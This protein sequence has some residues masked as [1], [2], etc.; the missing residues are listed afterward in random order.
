MGLW[1]WFRPP[2]T[3][4]AALIQTITHHF[5]IDCCR[6]SFCSKKTYPAN[7]KKRQA[8]ISKTPRAHVN[9]CGVQNY[10]IVPFI[11]LISPRDHRAS[12]Y[13]YKVKLSQS[14]IEK[15][16]ITNILKLSKKMTQFIKEV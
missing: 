11:R 2:T 4:A 9:L 5:T 8:P 13:L 6:Q 16:G 14:L 12:L 15:V 1:A 7:K 10:F 3:A